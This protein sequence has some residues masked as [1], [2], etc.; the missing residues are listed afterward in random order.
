MAF[1]YSQCN[2]GGLKSATEK[3]C[4]RRSTSAA[5]TIFASISPTSAKKYLSA[6][7][8]GFRTSYMRALYRYGYDKAKRGGLWENAPPSGG[9]VNFDAQS[10]KPVA[11]Q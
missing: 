4:M 10:K 3:S 1:S 2:A 6:G 7:S 11:L 5:A 8:F 9:L